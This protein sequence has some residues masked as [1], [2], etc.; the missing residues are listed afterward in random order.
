MNQNENDF[1]KNEAGHIKVRLKKT[2]GDIQGCRNHYLLEAIPG[3]M[4]VVEKVIN[5]FI[6]ETKNSIEFAN[7]QEELQHANYDQDELARLIRQYETHPSMQI[8]LNVAFV[9]WEN[10]PGTEERLRQIVDRADYILPGGSKAISSSQAP[11]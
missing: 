9:I 7:A 5:E 4:P 8:A 1:V 3:I 2:L 11:T 10:N 6:D